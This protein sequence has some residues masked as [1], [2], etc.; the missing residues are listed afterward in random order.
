VRVPEEYIFNACPE[1]VVYETLLVVRRQALH[2]T[3]GEAIEEVYAD[4]L[5][6]HYESLAYHYQR[7]Q[8]QE[9]AIHYLE[10]AGDKAKSQW[11]LQQTVMNYQQAVQLLASVEKTPARMKRHIDI[12]IKWADLIVPSPEVISALQ[13][14]EVYAEELADSERLA[15]AASFLGQLLSRFLLART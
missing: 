7:S 2:E 14:A 10:L 12:G 13:M 5:E 1:V 11:V 4:R 15:K 6:E 9:K 3:V 8:N